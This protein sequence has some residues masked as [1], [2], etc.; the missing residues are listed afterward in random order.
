MFTIDDIIDAHAKVKSWADFPQ[1]IQNLAEMWVTTYD[2]FVSDW[3]AVYEGMHGFVVK[4]PAKYDA[5]TIADSTDK[6]WFHERLQL[7]QDWWTDYMTFC[8]DA[9]KAWVE[10]WTMDILWMTCTYYDKKGN[11]ILAER[12]PTP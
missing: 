10:K 3:H 7:H 9:A 1:Y 12:V 2:I 8:K 11:S 6:D 5:L 4:A